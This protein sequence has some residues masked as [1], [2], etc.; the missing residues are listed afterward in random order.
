MHFSPH[1]QSLELRKHLSININR[2]M[3]PCF[4]E[5]AIVKILLC[6]CSPC[7][8]VLQLLFACTSHEMWCFEIASM[9]QRLCI[10]I[11]KLVSTCMNLQNGQK[12]RSPRKSL[13]IA[14]T[15]FC[16]CWRQNCI[17]FSVIEKLA[18]DMCIFM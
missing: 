18:S 6:Q 7:F 8:V 2:N 17:K 14:D 10:N 13:D 15:M 4:G 1:M 16:L 12:S 11:N 9:M 5:N 3:L